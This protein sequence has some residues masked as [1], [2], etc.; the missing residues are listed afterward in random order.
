MSSLLGAT[1]ET[2]FS[3]IATLIKIIISPLDA[4]I[5]NLLPDVAK[6]TNYITDFLNLCLTSIGWVID[7]L[8]IPTGLITI[9][10]S[11]FTFKYTLTFSVFIIKIILGWVKNYK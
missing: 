4:I 7:V 2:V 5:M 6:F 9:V 1:I 3:V 11:Y 10:I 8:G